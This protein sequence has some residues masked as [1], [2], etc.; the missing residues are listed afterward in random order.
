VGTSNF[1]EG[2]RTADVVDIGRRKIKVAGKGNGKEEPVS[3]AIRPENVEVFKGNETPQVPE[4]V[5]LVPGRIEVVV[6]QGAAVRLLIRLDGEEII[7]DIIEKDFEQRALKQGDQV[8]IYC[9]PQSYLVFPGE[10]VSK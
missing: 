1:F 9:S 2:H 3:L 7:S 10:L 4:P 5:N 8:Y 6:F